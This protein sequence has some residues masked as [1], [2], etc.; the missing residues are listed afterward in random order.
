M[1]VT[2]HCNCLN[3]CLKARWEQ[4][5]KLSEKMI[6]KHPDTYQQI[7]ASLNAVCE[8]IIDIEA[9]FDTARRLSSLLETMGAGTVFYNYFYEQIDPCKSGDIRYFRMLCR[10]L[11][12]QITALNRW[13]KK[14]R[15]IR[16]IK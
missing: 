14:Q 11:R 15:E 13:R 5:Y 6:L 16:L 1:D 7:Q 10:D 3:C 2:T 12:E 9:Y 8:N 4:Y